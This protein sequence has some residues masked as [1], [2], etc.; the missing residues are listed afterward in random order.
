M[1]SGSIKSSY[2]SASSRAPWKST[3]G[4]SNAAI[5][6]VSPPLYL[7]GNTCELLQI[8]CGKSIAGLVYRLE[9]MQCLISGCIGGS[10]F[11]TSSRALSYSLWYYQ[12]FPS[13]PSP[14]KLLKNF[15]RRQSSLINKS[16]D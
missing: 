11:S 3:A 4:F 15:P 7:L 16:T 5:L 8:L 14:L 2:F 1:I 10:Y 6:S 9:L 12:A 13:S